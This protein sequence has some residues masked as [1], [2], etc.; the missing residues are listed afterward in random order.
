MLRKLKD[1]LTDANVMASVAAF[2]AP[3][4]PLTRPTSPPNSVGTRQIKVSAITTGKIETK[5]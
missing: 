1:K 5:Q 3:R 2:I 4:A